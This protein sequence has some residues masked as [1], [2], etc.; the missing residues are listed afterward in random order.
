[1]ARAPIQCTHQYI[2][3]YASAFGAFGVTSE[4]DSALGASD[5]IK[6]SLRE[7]KVLGIDDV[8]LR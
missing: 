1:M 6:N 8:T 7:E 5:S 3:I 2:Y 4:G